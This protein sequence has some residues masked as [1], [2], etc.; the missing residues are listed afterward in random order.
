MKQQPRTNARGGPERF[1]TIAA[2]ILADIVTG[3]P[4]R[5]PRTGG[6]LM[7]QPTRYTDPF[8]DT[9]EAIRWNPSDP[10]AAG[11]C[12]GWLMSAGADFHHPD[13]TGGTTTLTIR[14]VD[15]RPD[16]TAQPGD[17]I[18]RKRCVGVG[19]V[20][21]VVGDDVFAGAFTADEKAC[22]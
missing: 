2:P 6:D 13:G 4:V 18:V 17:W 8:G 7:T 11:T 22:R 9:V 16:R 21:A 3:Q 14:G 20:F 12:I 5:D 10:I 19:T 1:A 15:G